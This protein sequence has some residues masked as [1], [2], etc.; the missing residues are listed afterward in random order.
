MGLN[1][2]P[3][4]L[5]CGVKHHVPIPLDVGNEFLLIAEP[6]E[7]GVLVENIVVR[8]MQIRVPADQVVDVRPDEIAMS[9]ECNIRKSL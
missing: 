5:E 6:K 1:P 9:D 4:H 7:G 2:C 3:V 8:K